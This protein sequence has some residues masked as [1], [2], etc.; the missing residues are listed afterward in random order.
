MVT[1]TKDESEARATG[2]TTSESG[3]SARVASPREVRAWL[4]AGECV[5][6]DV[7][8]PDEHARERI[9]G[10]RLLPLS[11]FDPQQAAAMAG[12]GRKAVMHCRSGR[13]SADACRLAAPLEQQGITVLSMIGG[14]EAWKSAALP[15]EVN[16]R[17][18]GISVMRQVQLV[19]GVSVLAG[20]ALA[21]F[22]D[23]RF[24]AIPA[25]FGAGLTFA[26]ATGTCALA[27]L[28]AW[29]PW[30]RAKV[31]GASCSTGSCG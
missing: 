15:V 12:P 28:L 16:T 30:N 31:S 23:P 29:M 25:F 24:V 21:W 1:S 9:P 6:I 18:A 20:S 19:I 14:I 3:G 10:A 11:K 7:R 17:V 8:E 5:L 22:V 26:G 13:R 27:S 2:T 4:Q